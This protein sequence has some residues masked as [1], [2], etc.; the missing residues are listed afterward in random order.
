MKKLTGKILAGALALGCMCTA[1]S[2]GFFGWSMDDV[3]ESLKDNNYVVS[4]EKDIGLGDFEGY[5]AY[6]YAEEENDGEEWFELYEFQSARTAKLYYN[7][8]KTWRENKIEDLEAEI[9]LYEYVVDQYDNDMT[10]VSVT[11][12]EEY[13]KEL[14][15]DIEDYQEDLENMGRKGVYVWYGTS[16]GISDAF[17]NV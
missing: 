1:A 16:D 11:C 15:E 7:M 4:I 6:L 13:I 3:K 12:V 2:C 9:A 5:V 8:N 17:E 14:Q 10:D